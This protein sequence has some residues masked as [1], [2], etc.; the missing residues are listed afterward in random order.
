MRA[1]PSQSAALSSARSD[2]FADAPAH[3]RAMDAE[4]A[5]V[6]SPAINEADEGLEE[7]AAPE[8]ARAAKMRQLRE[9]LVRRPRPASRFCDCA[10]S[11]ARPLRSPSL[12]AH[13]HSKPPP[14]PIAAMSSPST[15]EHAKRPPSRNG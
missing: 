1:L 14:S 11:A 8:D 5:D 13:A 9:R 12:Y 6:D 2:I 10:A 7:A 15:I 4:L 3:S